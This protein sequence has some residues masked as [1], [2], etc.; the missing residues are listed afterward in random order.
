MDFITWSNFL[1]FDESDPVLSNPVI[2]IIIKYICFLD[3]KDCIVKLT[4]SVSYEDEYQSLLFQN[5]DRIITKLKNDLSNVLPPPPAVTTCRLS[6]DDIL[7]RW[8]KYQNENS[9]TNKYETK[10]LKNVD[11]A[12]N[13]SWPEIVNVQC[14]DV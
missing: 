1:G 11:R 9:Q 3:S 10:E 13:W 6:V 8:Y 7:N 4:S 14:F 12:K 2:E 5:R